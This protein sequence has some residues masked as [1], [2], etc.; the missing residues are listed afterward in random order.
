MNRRSVGR[1]IQHT[2]A[3]WTS[4]GALIDEL[5]LDSLDLPPSLLAGMVRNFAQKDSEQVTSILRVPG[6]HYVLRVRVTPA[7]VLTVAVGP[8]SAIIAP[9]RVGRLLDPSGAELPLYRLTLSPPTDPSAPTA[10][11]RWRRER[12]MLRN[13]YPLDLP[14]GRRIVHAVVE[15]RGPV[16]LFVR[17]VLVVLL[18]AAVLATL[19]FAAEL[20]AG[21]Q[22]PRPRWWSL[23][24]SFR[25]RLAVALAGLLPAAGHRICGLELCSS[26]RRGATQPRSPHHP[27]ASRR[28]AQLPAASFRETMPRSASSCAS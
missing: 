4:G 20:V 11:P 16:P 14:S 10:P 12:W 18:D 24:R 19:W 9:G 8:R 21:A 28:G 23:A 25:M 15:L 27:D 26:G 17:G 3:L 7:E 1:D 5:T 6:I 22:P 13:E 2:L